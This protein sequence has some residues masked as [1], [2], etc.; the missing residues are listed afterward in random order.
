MTKFYDRKV[1]LQKIETTEGTDA[2]PVV[3]ADAILTRDYAPNV[4]DMDTRTRNLDLPWFGARPVIPINLRR[5]ATFNVDLAGAGTATGVPAWMKL[6]RLAGFDAG[7]VGASS[8]VQ[9]PISASIPSAT[10]W[11]YLDNLLLKAIGARANV[12]I[13]IEDDEFP[14]FAYTVLGRAPSTGG[15][16]ESSPAGPTLTAWKDP[17]VAST[18]N[19]TFSLDGFALPLRRL[20]LNS[21]NDLAFRSLIGPVDRVTWRNRAWGGTIL[22]ELPDLASKDYFQKLR[23]GTTMV[24]SVTHGTAAGNIVSIAAPKV[25]ITSIDLPDEDGIMMLS[26][27]VI[28]QPNAGNDEITFTSS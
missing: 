13:R 15:E 23:P 3:G 10:H 28:L 18:E 7:V 21:N 11:A 22:G 16:T 20:E 5:G 26:L 17:V 6:N 19:T 4:F 8:V 12:G 24:L 9:T 2:S 27:G 25:Q 1:I 14:Y